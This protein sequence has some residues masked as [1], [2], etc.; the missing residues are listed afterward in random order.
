MTNL[1]NQF[2][3][4]SLNQLIYVGMRTCNAESQN[5]SAKGSNFKEDNRALPLLELLHY[6]GNNALAE[7]LWNQALQNCILHKKFT[8]NRYCNTTTYLS[9]YARYCNTTTYLSFYAKFG[10]NTGPA[11]ALAT[12]HLSKY[13]YHRGVSRQNEDG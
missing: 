13:K 2:H 12:E 6:G 11:T 3:P 5:R 8:C 10:Q 1:R 4:F 9:F 7:K